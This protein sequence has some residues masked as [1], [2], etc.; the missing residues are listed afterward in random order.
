M[1]A[2][3]A[4]RTSVISSTETI[5]VMS[6]SFVDEREIGPRVL[7]E[8][9]FGASLGARGA[10]FIESRKNR[11]VSSRAPHGSS[12]NALAARRFPRKAGRGNQGFTLVR[13]DRSETLS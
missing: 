3:A 1:G 4:A 10:R 2:I 6:L 9:M 5:L 12:F 11:R 8:K 7:A 13:S